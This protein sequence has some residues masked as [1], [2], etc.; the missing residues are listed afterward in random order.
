MAG[1]TIFPSSNG[2]RD[3]YR[4]TVLR[5]FTNLMTLLAVAHLATFSKVHIRKQKLALRR[6]SSGEQ[7]SLT[8]APEPGLEPVQGHNAPPFPRPPRDSPIMV[9]LTWVT[10]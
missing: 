7:K 4:K 3:A 8:A 6:L 2:E 5:N 10:Q 9:A 1:N